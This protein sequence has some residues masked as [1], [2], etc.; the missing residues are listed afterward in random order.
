MVSLGIY[1]VLTAAQFDQ[2]P[3]AEK[4]ERGRA[5]IG[6]RH[7]ATSLVDWQLLEQ[8]LDRP[9]GPPDGRRASA[10]EHG[11]A[12]LKQLRDMRDFLRDERIPVDTAAAINDFK[13]T[14]ASAK[15]AIG[16]A[17]LVDIAPI[18]VEHM[19]P[20]VRETIERAEA[21]AIPAGV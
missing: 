11:L 6:N 9:F 15:R 12:E 17:K 7:L 4:L 10:A 3:A 19:G 8:F 13:Q 18:D 2:M 21:A 5:A 20:A 1:R 14:I 16:R